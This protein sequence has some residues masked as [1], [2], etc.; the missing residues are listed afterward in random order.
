MKKRFHRSMLVVAIIGA[1]FVPIASHAAESDCCTLT[2][3]DATTT[4]N[5]PV[6]LQ[7][8]FLEVNPTD[9]P[10]GCPISRSQIDFSIDGAYVGSAVTDQGGIARLIVTPAQDMHVGRHSITASHDFDS[11]PADVLTSSA[12]LTISKDA[13]TLT[14]HKGY[15]EAQLLDDEN[16]PL[17]GA[18]VHF[19]VTGPDRAEHDICNAFTDAAG[20]ARC[21]P[22]TGAGLTIADVTQTHYT[23]TFD[24]TGDYVGSSGGADLID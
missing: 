11:F 6:T 2:A 8:V 7:A 20:N 16:A 24:G 15:F 14:A 19:H 12:T 3:S 18:A 22:V 1:C 13:T 17:S 21:I 5:D 4:F 23:A 9:C 10:S